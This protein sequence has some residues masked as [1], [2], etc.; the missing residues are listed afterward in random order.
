MNGPFASPPLARPRHN[1]RDLCGIGRNHSLPI[2]SPFDVSGN[3]KTSKSSSRTCFPSGQ[4]VGR[5][6]QMAFPRCARPC[7]RTSPGSRWATTERDLTRM[8]DRFLDQLDHE[9]GSPGQEM[10]EQYCP[11]KEV[12]VEAER[13]ASDTLTGTHSRIISSFDV[14]T[15]VAH[16]ET[17]STFVCALPLMC[18]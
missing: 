15:Q 2:G 12:L 10:N 17:H 18:L 8:L 5:S 3:V 4:S 1:V 13:K 11:L 7:A 9:Q 16:A 14:F 6:A